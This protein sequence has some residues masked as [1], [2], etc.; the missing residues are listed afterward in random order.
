[1]FGLLETSHHLAVQKQRFSTICITYISSLRYQLVTHHNLWQVDISHLIFKLCM[2][3]IE[4]LSFSADTQCNQVRVVQ[5]MFETL[6]SKLLQQGCSLLGWW[7][8][9]TKWPIFL[10]LRRS[11]LVVKDSKMLQKCKKLS[12]KKLKIVCWRCTFTSKSL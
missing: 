6:P 4:I 11:I 10:A 1:M 2:I 3:Y 5:N 12:Y 7:D 8:L 9:G